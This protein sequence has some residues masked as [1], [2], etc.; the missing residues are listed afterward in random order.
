[1][2]TH[3]PLTVAPCPFLTHGTKVTVKCGL[4][5]GLEGIVVYKKGK[6]RVVISVQMLG[7]SISAEVATEDLALRLAA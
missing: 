6:A 4:L 7:R 5:N 1:M 3:A 2:T